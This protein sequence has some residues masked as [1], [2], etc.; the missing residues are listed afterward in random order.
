MSIMFPT[1][2]FTQTI[3]RLSISCCLIFMLLGIA[4]AEV[5][6]AQEFLNQRL[7][8]SWHMQKI[9]TIL[10]DLEVK[11]NVRFLYSPELVNSNRQIS[12]TRRNSKFSS[13]LNDLSEQLNLTYEISGKSIILKPK[14]GSLKSIPTSEIPQETSID[15][16]ISGRITDENGE[17]LPGVSI[18]VKGTT[19]GTSTDVD[20]TF[21]LT[22]P[23]QTES[24]IISYIGYVTQEIVLG[25]LTQIEVSLEPDI[26]SLGEVVVVGY[27]SVRKRDLTGSVGSVGSE[28]IAS[29]GTTSVMSALQGSV[30]GVD[31]SSNSVKPGGGFTIQIRGKNSLAGGEPLYVVDGVVTSDINFLNPNDIEQI[32]ILKDASSTAIYGSRGS[33]GVVLV[34]TKNAGTPGATRTSITYDGYYS[35]R[36]LARIP[37]FMTG[38]EWV[39]FRTSAYYEYRN[40]EYVLPS[41]AVILQNSPLLA[42][43]LYNEDDV[44][45][46]GLG[47]R[48]GQQ[49]NHFLG[50]TGSTE[51]LSYNMGIGYQKEEGNFVREDLNRYTFKLSA[52][53]QA[54][55]FFSAGGSINFNLG[56]NNSGSEHGYRDILR[57]PPIL[58]A[59]DENGNLIEQPGIA[60]SIQGSGNFTSS[61]NPLI[62]INSGT[63]EVRRYDMLGSMFAE[64]RPFEG[65]SFRSTLLPRFNRTRTGRYYGIVPG[66]RNQ[67]QAFQSNTENFEFT[68]DNVLSYNTQF[69]GDHNLNVQLIQ[70]AYRTRYERIQAA[71]NNLPY[72]SQWY[73]LFSGNFVSGSSNTAYSETSLLSYAGRANYDYK[74]KYLVTATLRYDGSSKLKNKWKA[75]PSAAVAWRISEEDFLANNSVVSDLKARLSLGF[76][77]NNNGISAYGAQQTPETGS[78]VWYDFDGSVVSGFAPGRP[79][80]QQITWEKTRELNFGIDFA[81]FKHRIS[82]TL[83]LYDKLS[84]GL[85]MSRALTIES[86]VPSMTDNIGSVSNKGVEVSLNTI[87]FSRANFEWSTRFIF[88]HNKNAIVSLYGKKEDVPGEA[89]FIG[90]P[91]DVIYDYRIIGIWKLAQADEALQWGQQPGQAIA[92]DINGDGRITAADDRVILG[93]PLPDWTGSLTSNLRFKNWDF[94]FNFFTRQGV[95]VADRFL[96]EFGPQNNQR[97]RPKIRFDYY[98]PPNVMRYDWNTWGTDAAGKPTPTWGTSGAGNEDAAHAHYINRGPYYGNN[99]MYTDASFIKVRNITLGYTLPNH[100]L[101]RL[102]VKQLRV[103]ANILNPFTFTR[104]PGWDPEYATTAL[105]SGNGPSNIT[106]Q[107][108]LNL[109]F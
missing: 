84:D 40:G 72:D 19:S 52:E 2:H 31:I 32:D 93:S 10:E 74:G 11:A 14:M 75:F 59:Y 94:S 35:V 82:G 54:S 7:S 28:D 66:N 16:R 58:G 107:F 55:K 104:Y 26:K 81:L 3:R 51:K 56:I 95:F 13:I 29:R 91:I 50:I 61:P 15:K 71:S 102:K 76:S 109:K 24:L 79:V 63:Q 67:D 44:D 80:N 53:H 96:E 30:A 98:I 108:G 43:R 89:R 88:S 21:S 100:T 49:Q 47:T 106:Y 60:A 4:R 1:Y 85:L 9:E 5:V 97:G 25:N 39:D 77:G 18:Q 86:G 70:S 38:R 62:E 105:S 34:K 27:G 6:Y 99:G 33:N 103:Y 17:P 87:N 73:N 78:V 41:P 8:V 101:E 90:Q 69:S 20:G 57:M 83:D 22:V 45:W 65:L 42:E 12:F 46:L 92:E 48:T 68:W 23:D 36:K 64:F 37:D